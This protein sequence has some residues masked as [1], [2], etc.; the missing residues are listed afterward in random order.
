MAARFFARVANATCAALAKKTGHVKL[1]E[2]EGMGLTIWMIL[3]F[4]QKEKPRTEV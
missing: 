1:K 2:A 4:D 3:I